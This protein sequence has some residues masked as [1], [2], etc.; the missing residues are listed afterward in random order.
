MFKSAAPN[1]VI[2][3]SNTSILSITQGRLL[4][5]TKIIE[6]DQSLKEDRE[7]YKTAEK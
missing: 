4:A 3:R 5:G 1:V 2:H 6:V 7:L